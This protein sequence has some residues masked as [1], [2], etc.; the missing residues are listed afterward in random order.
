MPH[1]GIFVHET[2]LNQIMAR[3]ELV[4]LPPTLDTK[5]ST[6]HT[7]TGSPITTHGSAQDIQSSDTFLICASMMSINRSCC[8]V[9]AV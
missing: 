2:T 9:G 1:G 5:R 8:W 7:S 3:P 6:F 4:L